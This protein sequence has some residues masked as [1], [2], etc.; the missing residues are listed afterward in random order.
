MTNVSVTVE[1]DLETNSEFAAR[2]ALIRL[3]GEIAHIVQYGGYRLGRSEGRFSEGQKNAGKC[4]VSKSGLG[5][6]W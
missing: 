4:H 1:I 6:L 5:G 2:A 3:P